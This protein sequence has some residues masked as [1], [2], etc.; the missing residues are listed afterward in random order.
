MGVQSVKIPVELELRQLQ[1]SINTLQ[2]ALNKLDPGSKIYKSIEASLFKLTQRFNSLEAESK[3][4]FGSVKEINSFEQNF[5]KVN[6]SVQ[7]LA[8]LLNKV[9]FEDLGQI[10]S[11]SDLKPIEEARN[12]IKQ[13]QSDLANIKTDKMNELANS[14]QDFKSV[15]D[16]IKGSTFKD[17]LGG[18]DK[19]ID[20]T[21]KSIENS[22]ENIQK[23]TDSIQETQDK[24]DKLRKINTQGFDFS[25]FLTAD[26]KKFKGNQNFRGKEQLNVALSALGYDP[27]TINEVIKVATSNISEAQKL[28]R[29]KTTELI[30]KNNNTLKVGTTAKPALE[31][32]LQREEEA[33]KKFEA[34]KVSLENARTQL[35]GIELDPSTQQ[36]IDILNQQI[37]EQTQIIQQLKIKLLELSGIYD[38]T[39]N[40]I[41]NSGNAF[42][43]SKDKI[44]EAR[45]SMIRLAEAQEKL[46]SVK[47]AIKN[48]F[49]FNEV[50]NMSKNAVRNA[51]THIRELDKTMTEIAIVTDMTQQELWGQIDVYSALAQQYGATTKGVYE[52][53]QLYYQQGLQ[54][55]E[56]MDLTSETLKMARISSLSY[57]DATDY[58]T[59]ALRGFKL[60]MSDAQNI[61]DVY[62]NIAAVSASDTEELAVA[63]SKTASSA[64]AVGASFENTTAMIALMVETTREAPENIGSALKSIISRY[65]EMTSD[66]MKL[67]DSEGEEMS[68][69]K[70]DKA[71][72]SV[73]IS[74]QDAQG[75]FRNFD[76]VILEL[77]ES[78]DT[79]DKNTQRYIAT[80]MAGNR[81]QSRFLALVGNYE[82]LKELTEEAAN[83]ED[84]AQLQILKTMDSIETKLN[85][86]KVTYQEFYTNTGVEELIK[87]F[88]DFTTN[89]IKGLNDIPKT[90]NKLPIAAISTVSIIIKVVKASLTSIVAQINATIS[91]E[92]NKLKQQAAKDGTAHG[93]TYAEKFKA[94]MQ[95]IGGRNDGR[96]IL[97]GAL[98][99][100]GAAISTLGLSLSGVNQ[101][102]SQ[103]TTGIGNA[104]AGFGSIFTGGPMGW[105]TGI[106]SILSG[107]MT[108]IDGVYESTTEKIERLTEEKQ[109]FSDE[110]LL[111]KNEYKTLNDYKD[112]LE[113][114]TKA[115]YDS[116]EAYQE[117]LDLNNEIAS[118]YPELISSIDNEGNALITLTGSYDALSEAR[119]KAS[120]ASEQQIKTSIELAKEQRKQAKDNYEDA[121]LDLGNKLQGSSI[122]E[123][124]YL[125]NSIQALDDYLKKFD[126][127]FS[128]LDGGVQDKIYGALYS[129]DWI[130]LQNTLDDIAISQGADLKSL[131]TSEVLN[132]IFNAVENYNDRLVEETETIDFSKFEG[133][134]EFSDKYKEIDFTNINSILDFSK[135]LKESEIEIKSSAEKAGPEVSS[136][137]NGIYTLVGEIL[138]SEAGY[139]AAKRAVETEERLGIAQKVS[140]KGYAKT[141]E[142]S[143][144]DFLDESNAFNEII[145]Q[146]LYNNF[147]QLKEEAIKIGNTEFS[148]DDYAN[149]ESDYE[150]I[151][152]ALRNAYNSLFLDADRQSFINIIENLQNYSLSN[153]TKGLTDLDLK[154]EAIATVVE[155]WERNYSDAYYNFLKARGE[156]NKQLSKLT[157]AKILGTTALDDLAPKYYSS[158]LEQFTFINSQIENKLIK[159][160]KGQTYADNLIKLWEK[161]ETDLKFGD[162][163]QEAD[164][165]SLSGIYDFRQAVIDAGYSINDF[166]EELK[167]LAAN[168]KINV[169]TET[170]SLISKLNTSFKTFGE[171]ISKASEGM[172]LEEALKVA[173]KLDI[174]IANFK[175]EDGEFKMEGELNFQKLYDAY[176][177]KN[178]E[179]QTQL[180]TEVDTEIGRLQRKQTRSLEYKGVTFSEE[181]QAQLDSLIILRDNLNKIVGDYN[182]QLLQTFLLQNK[183]YQKYFNNLFADKQISDAVTNELVAAARQGEQ[184]FRN[185]LAQKG[186]EMTNASVEAFMKTIEGTYDDIIGII[187]EGKGLVSLT[188]FDWSP[189]DSLN[190]SDSQAVQKFYQELF[191]SNHEKFNE[192]WIG[193][194]E[195]QEIKAGTA[196]ANIAS[197]LD[198]IDIGAIG[199]LANSLNTEITNILGYFHLEDDGSYTSS[200]NEIRA[201]MQQFNI[202]TTAEIEDALKEYLNNIIS[203]IS[204][205]IEGSLTNV[206]FESLKDF[207]DGRLALEFTK[208]SEGL[209]LTKAS[210]IE[211]Y[212]ELKKIDSIQAQITFYDL[213]ESLEEAG[214]G[215]E[216]I[217]STMQTIAELNRELAD[218]P[219]SSERRAELERELAVAEE[220]LRVR[221]Q[222][223]DSFK[224]MD[225]DLPTGMQG[226]ENYWNS[227]GEAYKV[228]NESAKSGYMEIQDY[229]NIVNQMEAMAIAAGQEF[230]IGGMNAAQLIEK[231]MSSLKNIDGEGVKIA[232]EGV[233]IDFANAATDMGLSFDDGIKEMARSQIKMLDAAIRMLEAMVAM[234]NIDANSDGFLGLKEIFKEGANLED[235]IQESDWDKDVIEWADNLQD[236]AGKISIGSKSLLDA[237]ATLTPEQ[238]QN[239]L[240]QLMSIDWTLGDTDIASQIQNVLSAYFPDVDITQGKSVFDILEVPDDADKNAEHFTKWL[241]DMGLNARQYEDLMRYLDENT[242][243]V[244]TGGSLFKSIAKMLGVEEGTKQFDQLTAFTNS[245]YAQGFG[246]QDVIKVWDDITVTED[247]GKTIYTYNGQE[248][249]D[250]NNVIAARALKES[251]GLDVTGTGIVQ[252]EK[253]GEVIMTTGT[254]TLG[255]Q[256]ITVK[257]FDNGTTL[258]SSE[259][260][261]SQTFTSLTELLEE[262]FKMDQKS[263]STEMTKAEYFANYG[264]DITAEGLAN[265]S[266]EGIKE[267]LSSDIINQ[268]VQE[269]GGTRD[270]V[271]PIDGKDVTFAAGTS[272]TEIQQKLMEAIGIDSSQIETIVTAISTAISTA[273]WSPV[274]KAISEAL[275]GKVKTEEGVAEG[276]EI[277]ELTLKPEGLKV[278]ATDIEPT[279]SS[280]EEALSNIPITSLT[281]TPE[282]LY[283]DI[284]NKTPQLKEG[285]TVTIENIPSATGTVTGSITITNDG[286]WSAAESQTSPEVTGYTSANG[287]VKTVTINGSSFKVTPVAGAPTSLDGELNPVESGFVKVEGN[288]YSVDLS[289][290]IQLNPGMSLSGVTASSAQ[291]NATSYTVTFTNADGTTSQ[292]VIVQG[293]AQ[294]NAVLQ[295]ATL[296]DNGGWT[297][298][299][300]SAE[301]DASISTKSENALVNFFDTLVNK[302]KNIEITYQEPTPVGP[303][304]DT[305]TPGYYVYG[306]DN[307]SGNIASIGEYSKLDA[308]AVED[309]TAHV[310]NGTFQNGTFTITE[311][312]ADGTE[313]T[314]TATLVELQAG[315]VN[316][317]GVIP[318]STSNSNSSGSKGELNRGQNTNSNASNTP[319]LDMSAITA[320]FQSVGEAGLAA[321]ENISSATTKLTSIDTAPVSVASARISNLAKAADSIKATAASRI[322][323][324]VSALKAIPSSKIVEIKYKINVTVESSGDGTATG[325]ILGGSGITSFGKNTA[326][327]S[328]AKG[329][330]SG[331]ALA[332]GRKK[333]LMGEL[334]PELV[335][336]NGRYFIVGQNGA[337][338]VDLADDAIV[339]NHLQTKKLI[340]NGHAGTGKPVT[341]EANAV[342]LASGNVNG[343]AKASA[344]DALA[345]LKQ[346]RAMWQAL[347]D[348]SASDL[349]KKAGSG[350]GGGGGGGGGSTEDVKAVTGELERWYNLLRQIDSLEQ[351]IT[352]EQAKRANL[353]DG[354]KYVDSL[355][356]ELDMLKEQQQAYKKLAELQKDY[357]DRR[358]EDLLSTDYSKIFTYTEHGL[359]QYV[360]GENRGLD[361]LAKLN[362]RDA[363]GKLINNA[364]NAKAQLKYLK[365]VGFD[366]SILKYNDDGTK[367]ENEEQMMENFWANVDSWMEELDGLY[368]SYHE[369]TTN[370]EESTEKINEILQEY[371]DNQLAVEEKLMQAIQDR[372][373]AEIDRIQDEKDA[374]EEAAQDYIDGL[375]E[376]LSKER[377]MYQKNE[378]DAETAKLQRQLAILQRSGGSTS[379]IKSLQDQIDSRLQEVYFQEQ[380]NQIDAIQEASDNQIEK[381][382]TQI[383]LMTETLEYQKENG[384]LWQEVY[385]MMNNWTPE[386]LLQFVEQ[387]T[388]SYK[389][390]SALEN[391]EKSK[392]TLKE[393]EIWVANRTNKEREQA[394]NDYY[395]SA[396]YDK[397]LKEANKDKAFSAY[398]TAYESGGK[399]AAETA[400]NKVFENAKNSNV[401]QEDSTSKI[402]EEKKEPAK[403][404]PPISMTGKLKGGNVNMRAKADASSKVIKKIPKGTTVTLTGM[405]K[406]KNDGYY[407]FKASAAGKSGYMAYTSRW[408]DF[409]GNVNELPKFEKG[410]LVDFTGPA[411]VDGSKSKPE[412][413]LSAEDTAMLKSKIFSNSDGS[414]RALVAALEAITNDTSK[415]SA[416]TNTESIVIQN[417]Q[418]NIQPGTISNDYDARRAGEMA[419]EEMLKIA[420]KTTN[421][422]VSR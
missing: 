41:Q 242:K 378:T 325:R 171:E 47:H 328:L 292:S 354:Y 44:N 232:M 159:S 338:F 144:Y 390:D 416:Q 110:A 216:D 4:S 114:L 107:A 315:T 140:N 365:N 14:S 296:G 339:F 350:G 19:E 309:I 394:W 125:N 42:E 241:N 279:L 153:L 419:L 402:E 54:T 355:E 364:V 318:T 368:D 65:G 327:G 247:N 84:A 291:V 219:V 101:Q 157:G 254:I 13:L 340:K 211:V 25:Q 20:S 213:A 94:A 7:E 35:K 367:A 267:V 421:R 405:S 334:G 208:T 300:I 74:L 384:L 49:G 126:I 302:L 103:M 163:L 320:Q 167:A 412:A 102:I 129:Q 119:L 53:S 366:T 189:K 393:S 299:G 359:M 175:F 262:S 151:A 106:I 46:D 62:S 265:V 391:E 146:N 230:S 258:Y 158:V 72:Q 381:L 266:V 39:E 48:W 387:Y 223:P 23:Y 290:G 91:Q 69:N 377:D 9:S 297:L 161:S 342:A 276:I 89:V 382:Q 414:L 395:N 179:L 388:K 284:A 97:S 287:T 45:A 349:G 26:K 52:V 389:E 201:L 58:M 319:L 275:T 33:L 30:N 196:I 351:H 289:S 313:L 282:T 99:V 154:P 304:P 274:G 286:I 217:A 183:S 118:K 301:V 249:T 246:I 263:G 295:N 113:Q 303:D 264:V 8:Y 411:W 40:I 260:T 43:L 152:E 16:G 294:L 362:E 192:A 17:K 243:I 398:Q 316:F 178:N 314:T 12:K 172:D 96:G 256:E 64:E 10:F 29:A 344:S 333:T 363:T 132:S 280:G 105:V 185:L 173:E 57:S 386:Q 347:L 336:S 198:S 176:V 400:A 156:Q 248:Y 392:E 143:S 130:S 357:Y 200:E 120:E 227:V 188:E 332:S 361:I 133:L 186:L 396:N 15:I 145:T 104:I 224:F 324:L 261:G 321:A 269:A 191:A 331:Q 131:D 346:I 239:V 59:V 128:K 233:G 87:G 100:T 136:Y 77:A 312:K 322:W 409:N 121:I 255:G 358:R 244:G 240:N 399:E 288:Y 93:R 250:I 108:F 406:K 141:F 6:D 356:A 326:S 234:E 226:P 413:F 273:D 374:L 197:S 238:V 408:G 60:E 92:S 86:L 323:N 78:W 259:K 253:T 212:T 306:I 88:L 98:S 305:S 165:T 353:M 181:E 268:K 271:I 147:K 298:S 117:W 410:G 418:V 237:L 138:S 51:I 417:A 330:I 116:D 149:F 166:D 80:V 155:V 343:P 229:V 277:G 11:D 195:N 285:Q 81:Q 278:D 369:A 310:D 345:E 22:K 1:G 397:E 337:E 28:L 370:F 202:Q 37:E 308:S 214:S 76:D 209:K 75:Q 170:D 168:I 61:V 164:L 220:I 210:V 215:Y 55:A 150:K 180:K 376:A 38:D 221:S 335:V 352:L 203:I 251:T 379:E 371:I 32:L 380:Q 177:G 407:W 66:P 415:Y 82:R 148:L 73:G 403:A 5:N 190:T 34:K 372:E 139:E 79:I 36:S 231:G 3:K 401:Q 123:I 124:D 169:V 184:E 317:G 199:E 225:K 283:I 329:N 194:L 174:S 222:D 134:E 56:V 235:G 83:S 307:N 21:D 218:A 385:E 383:D 207:F 206:E 375:N 252:N 293:E 281:L 137:I 404:E 90:F 205:G 270:I 245:M 85:Q 63:M 111:A 67:V 162:L 204:N 272:E 257:G 348:S 122:E 70:V 115:R 18:L 236:A 341:N 311:M 187:N 109:K 27:K 2:N 31:I 24:I 422:V 71:L 127:S 193:Y 373:Q 95:G 50:I 68:L 112:K 360:D 135:Y 142:D 420:R 182:K 160:D 228:M